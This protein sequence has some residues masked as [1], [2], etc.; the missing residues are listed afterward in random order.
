MIYL[1][2]WWV[3]GKVKTTSKLPP[4]L[5]IECPRCRSERDLFDYIVDLDGRLGP[6]FKCTLKR[7]GLREWITLAGWPKNQLKKAGKMLPYIIAESITSSDD[8]DEE[9]PP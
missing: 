5:Y 6:I 1:E 4:G 2:H 9:S 7:C 3:I 8:T